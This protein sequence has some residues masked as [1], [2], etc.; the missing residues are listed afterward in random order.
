MISYQITN[1]D[2]GT[3]TQPY[4]AEVILD[5]AEDPIFEYACH[6][7]NYGM[8]YILSGHRAQERFAREAETQ[9]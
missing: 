8:T 4:T 3:Y 9:N 1:S 5:Y 6:E 7:G 2:P